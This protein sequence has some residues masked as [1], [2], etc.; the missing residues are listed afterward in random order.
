MKEVIISKITTS[1]PKYKKL[2]HFR[3]ELLRKPLGLDLFTEDLS[4]DD[5]DIIL[6]A[7]D[8]ENIV[9]CV[10]LHPVSE[11]NI[12]LRQMAVDS[13]KQGK[14]IGRV[15]VEEAE[16]SAIDKGFKRMILHARV[17]AQGFYSKMGYNPIG[18]VFTEVTI[19]HIA[20]EKLLA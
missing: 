14:G 17:P 12:K 8:K 18:E 13:S 9:G 7:E 15:L 1:D 2:L 6:V 11:S 3:N 4:D 5:K 20:M 16:R 19:P 10:M